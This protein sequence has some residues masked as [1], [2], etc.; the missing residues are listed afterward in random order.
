MIE[1]P[2]YYEELRRLKKFL[3]ED[4]KLKFDTKFI[5]SLKV[6]INQNLKGGKTNPPNN[7]YSKSLRLCATKKNQNQKLNGDLKGK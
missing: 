1:E 3:F 2:N 7:N 4:D 5:E 6:I